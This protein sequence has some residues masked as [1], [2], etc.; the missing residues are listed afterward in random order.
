MGVVAVRELADKLIRLRQAAGLLHLC[1]GG[2]LVSPTQIFPDGTAEQHVFLQHHGYLVA[3]SLQVV[4]AHIH[5]AHAHSALSGVIQTGDEL[6][7][8]GFGRAR[9]ADNADGL[10]GT[11]VQVNA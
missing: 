11:N 6:D 10:A 3:Q 4:A 8:R 1:I 2:V 9:A 7:Q 5:T